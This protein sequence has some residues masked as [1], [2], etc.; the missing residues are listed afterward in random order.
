M[1][2]FL[3]FALFIGAAMS[4]TAFP[5]L[6]RILTDRRMHR[7]ETG[8]IALAC[9][10]TDDILAWTLLAVVIAIGGG[11]GEDNQWLVLLAVPFALFALLVV[12]PQLTR[13][14]TAYEKAGRL[15][16]GIMSVVL[17][18]L[19]L[20][21]AATEYSTCTTSSARSSSARSS[22][23][24]GRRRCA[25]RSWSGSSRSRCCSCYRC[26]SW[27]RGST[28]TSGGCRARTSFSWR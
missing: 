12:R 18:G 22:R 9:A 23:T 6:A 3:P 16:P 1:T 15:T 25:T 24:R 27:C 5:V 10:A 17:V 7:T 20:F 11:Q 28:S 13:L 14:T 2:D 21:A 19:L 8:G 26:S 4:V